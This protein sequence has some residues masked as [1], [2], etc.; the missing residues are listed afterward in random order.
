MMKKLPLVAAFAVLWTACVDQPLLD[1]GM[2]GESGSTG[3][4]GSNSSGGSN[5]SSGSST[6]TAGKNTGGGNVLPPLGGSPST[7]GSGGDGGGMAGGG[8]AG[9]AAGGAGGASGSGGSGG[10]GFP[11]TTTCAE[12]AAKFG[13][14]GFYATANRMVQDSFTIEAWIN[15]SATSLTGPSNR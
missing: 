15:T 6:S 4:G 13:T 8:G 5:G 2:G 7:S 1:Q 10:M 11:K 14:F 9:G 3:S 12:Y